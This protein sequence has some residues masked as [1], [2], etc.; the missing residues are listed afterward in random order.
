MRT[1][2]L[3]LLAACGPGSRPSDRPDAGDGMVESNVDCA[4]YTWTV[5]HAGGEVETT[6]Y[7]R[8]VVSDVRVGDDFLVIRCLVPA[9]S[10]PVCPAGASCS[11]TA[12]PVGQTC[13]AS[14]DGSFVGGALVVDCGS[15]YERRN[16]SGAVVA[17]QGNLL[18]SVRLIR[19]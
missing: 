1:T 3:L 18:E 8:A 15:S 16:S 9:A 6:T 7:R 2:I 10:V 11:G 17:S 4:E 12:G 19:R 5:T 14:R 13:H